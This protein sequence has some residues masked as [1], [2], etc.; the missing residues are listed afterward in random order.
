MPPEPSFLARV[1]FRPTVDLGR[2][3]VPE[4]LTPLTYT[5]LY[6]QLSPGQAL[7]YNQLNG[8]YFNEV[9]GLFEE[10][11]G[12]EVPEHLLREEDSFPVRQFLREEIA[13]RAAFERLNRLCAPDWYS[14]R[15]YVLLRR[16]PASNWA[17]RVAARNLGFLPCLL[18]VMLAMEEHEVWVAERFTVSDEGLEPNFVALQRA[19]GEDERRHV[20]LDADLLA[21]LHGTLPG[22]WRRANAGA[23][24]WIL[25]TWLCAPGRASARIL[26]RLLAEFPD[27][28]PLRGRMLKELAALGRNPD[29]QRMMYSRESTPLLFGLFDRFPEFQAMEKVLLAYRFQGDPR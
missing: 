13:H 21:R 24:A 14:D 26:D 7:R 12:R 8:L 23:F 20:G 22:P 2:R 11:L 3:F 16:P 17:I 6:A 18:W 25:K 28:A 5:P 10:T 15:T 1:G 19:H 9:I 4:C 27:L 29:Y